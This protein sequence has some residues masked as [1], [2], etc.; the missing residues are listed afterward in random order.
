MILIAA[1]AT[2]SA[3]IVVPAQDAQPIQDRGVVNIGSDFP[4]G[5]LDMVAKFSGA[6]QLLDLLTCMKMDPHKRWRADYSQKDNGVVF[7]TDVQ[8]ACCSMVM[9]YWVENH[10]DWSKIFTPHVNLGE[11]C[12]EAWLTK[13]K[14]ADIDTLRGVIGDGVQRQ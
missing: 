14:P 11:E 13:M 1:M 2:I 12:T 10:E 4:A 8:P 3:A 6:N 7:L 5:L 9:H